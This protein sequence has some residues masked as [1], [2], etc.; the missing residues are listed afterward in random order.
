[1]MMMIMIIGRERGG[2]GNLK[3]EM[4]FDQQRQN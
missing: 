4:G 2:G 1:M 3:R